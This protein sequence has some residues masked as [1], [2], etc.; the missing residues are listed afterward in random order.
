M[1]QRQGDYALRLQ[2][3]EIASDEDVLAG[4]VLRIKLTAGLQANGLVGRLSCR[5]VGVETVLLAVLAA[6][7]GPEVAS[8]VLCGSRGV[9][10]V[11]AGNVGVHDERFVQAT[12]EAFR[13]LF[14]DGPRL[15]S[16]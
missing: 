16:C 9:L 2:D 3:L 10:G 15:D 7:L 12:R 14:L 13:A 8:V 6:P 11:A 5:A 1:G 4:S